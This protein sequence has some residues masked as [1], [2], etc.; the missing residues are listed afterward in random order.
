MKNLAHQPKV[1]FDFCLLVCL[2]YLIN[3]EILY[4]ALQ[5]KGRC[6]QQ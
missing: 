5:D 3:V 2:L 6:E 4:L 1:Y